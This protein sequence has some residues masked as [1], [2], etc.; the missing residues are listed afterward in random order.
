MHFRLE[1]LVP[2][3]EVVMCLGPI[4]NIL[5]IGFLIGYTQC[6]PAPL[7]NDTVSTA[8]GNHKI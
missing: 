1:Q 8:T 4:I 6:S 7:Q 2:P 5:L 3:V